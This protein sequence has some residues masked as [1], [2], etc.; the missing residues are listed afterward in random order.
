MKMGRAVIHIS[1]IMDNEKWYITGFQLNSP[2]F[3]NPQQVSGGSADDARDPADTAA[4]EREVADLLA[5][6]DTITIRKNIKKLQAVARKY[7]ASGADENLIPILEKILEADA[8]D[9]STQFKLATLLAKNGHG[10]KARQKAL[11]V[12]NFSE[13][14]TLINQ[15]GQFLKRS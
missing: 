15:A 7:E 10:T 3:N 1:C 4:L 12:Y 2:V 11:Q 14:E 13:D 5:T 9:L 8:T 6:G